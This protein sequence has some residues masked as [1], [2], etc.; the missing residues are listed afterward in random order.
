MPLIGVLL[1]IVCIIKFIIICFIIIIN[2][3]CSVSSDVISI[4]AITIAITVSV[5]NELDCS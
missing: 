2:R 3:H 4:I 5:N 1:L